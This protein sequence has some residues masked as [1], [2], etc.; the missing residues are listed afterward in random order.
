MS[1]TSFDPMVQAAN[2]SWLEH[3]EPWLLP[4]GQRDFNHH[5]VHMKGFSG[6]NSVTPTLLSSW[7]MGGVRGSEE[8]WSEVK[9]SEMKWDG[10]K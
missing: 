3:L 7:R 9:G 8:E 6:Q 2:S 1:F 4:M 10:V 5:V